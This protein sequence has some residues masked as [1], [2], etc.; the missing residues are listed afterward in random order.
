MDVEAHA[1]H[2]RGWQINA[3]HNYM[4]L[5]YMSIVFSPLLCATYRIL[6]GFPFFYLCVYVQLAF[7]P[8]E[9]AQDSWRQLLRRRQGAC[10]VP[11]PACR[12]QVVS[13]TPLVQIVNKEGLVLADGR[14]VCPR[15]RGGASSCRLVLRRRLPF[16]LSEAVVSNQLSS[17]S[18]QLLYRLGY[19]ILF[20][21]FCI[22]TV[23]DQFSSL[24]EQVSARVSL[25]AVWHVRIY[26]APLLLS[27]SDLLLCTGPFL[28]CHSV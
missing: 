15:E 25:P 7:Q 17:L 21:F 3:N 4:K 28:T 19:G 24:S 5:T 10:R 20:L 12:V 2:C 13:C 8:G 23:S 6:C 14:G 16:L 11:C 18:E 22:F 9:G 1:T 27:C 26:H